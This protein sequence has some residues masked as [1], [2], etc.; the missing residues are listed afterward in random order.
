[1]QQNN[2]A[3]IIGDDNIV[4]QENVNIGGNGDVGQKN[5]AKVKGNKNKERQKNKN[6][7]KTTR[8]RST[9]TNTQ[10]DKNTKNGN[11]AQENN[12]NIQG[13]NNKVKQLNINAGQVII[14][15]HYHKTEEHYHIV[16][17]PDSESYS[18]TPNDGM[19]GWNVSVTYDPN[20]M[21]Q[22]QAENPQAENPQV[23][24]PQVKTPQVEKSK[25]DKT[26]ADKF[27]TGIEKV[28]ALGD[29]QTYAMK[30]MNMARKFGKKSIWAK[31]VN[32][33][34]KLQE[35]QKLTEEQKKQMAQQVINM[36]LKDTGQAA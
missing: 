31:A 35:N 17:K 10:G 24:V 36:A 14:E 12:A 22:P 28:E 34:Q 2:D 3:E 11:V 25:K 20:I 16:R 30:K 9:K 32:D 4:D 19:Y 21:N 26:K 8:R 1:M 5:K 18:Y 29:L 15:N 27:K 23:E 33:I 13:N 6:Q 7:G